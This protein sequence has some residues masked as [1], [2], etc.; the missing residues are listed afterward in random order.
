MHLH[1]HE[2]TIATC[3]TCSK[4]V[5]ILAEIPQ[6]YRPTHPFILALDTTPG[7]QELGRLLENPVTAVR[8]VE[9]LKRELLASKQPTD[10]R[11][12]WITEPP[13]SGFWNDGS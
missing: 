3:A 6:N 1:S 2:S 4:G 7:A 5:T 13:G 12:A 8:A 11:T 9:I 10:P